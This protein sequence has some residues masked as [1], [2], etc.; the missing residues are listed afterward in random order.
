[1]APNVMEGMEPLSLPTMVVRLFV[2]ITILAK[3]LV[4]HLTELNT[5]SP[6]VLGVSPRKINE[7]ICLYTGFY[8]KVLNSQM[9]ETK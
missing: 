3:R 5:C 9:L 8:G 1:M 6:Y 7:I 4:D 2:A